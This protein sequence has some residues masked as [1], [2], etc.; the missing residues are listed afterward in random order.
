MKYGRKTTVAG[1]HDPINWK[2]FGPA[3][4]HLSKYLNQNIRGLESKVKNGKILGQTQRKKGVV[5][6][7]SAYF[8]DRRDDGKAE[9]H[10]SVGSRDGRKAKER[11]EEIGRLFPKYLGPF[12]GS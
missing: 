3:L 2:G 5:I 10:Y 4:E 1:V 11:V 6:D 12:V 9:M 8:S 7:I